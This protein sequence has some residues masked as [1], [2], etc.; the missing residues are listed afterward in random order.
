ML[1]LSSEFVSGCVQLTPF[2]LLEKTP[3]TSACRPDSALQ[4]STERT[5]IIRECV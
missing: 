5:S 1:T 2:L 4:T 3:L